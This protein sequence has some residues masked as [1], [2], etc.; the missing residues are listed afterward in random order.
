MLIQE[1][2]GQT[3][4]PADLLEEN[5]SQDPAALP[6]EVGEIALDVWEDAK[7]V[8][9]L[10]PMA[11]VNPKD[12]ELS[13]TDDTITIKGSRHNEHQ[14]TD[15]NQLLQECFWGDFERTYALPVSVDGEKAKATLKNGLLTVIIP[16]AHKSKI[17][18]IEVKTE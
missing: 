4:E 11:G 16:K 12:L 9:I 5:V 18:V 13:L 8:I 6:Q 2:T 3:V 1:D 7:S 10:A 17:N 15:G 14:K